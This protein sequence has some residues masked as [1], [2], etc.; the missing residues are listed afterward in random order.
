MEG[1][2]GGVPPL[3]LQCTA[4]LIHHCGTPPAIGTCIGPQSVAV[5][6]LFRQPSA[7]PGPHNALPSQAAN[8]QVCRHAREGGGVQTVESDGPERAPTTG[9]SQYGALLPG[10]VLSG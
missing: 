3:L 6:H 4:V 2:P 8:G 1:S 9:I 7:P 5:T 10:M